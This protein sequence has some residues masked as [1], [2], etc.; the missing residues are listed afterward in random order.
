MK[1]Q[2]QKIKAIG[3]LTIIATA[4]TVLLSPGMIFPDA[5]RNAVR[6]LPHSRRGDQY[7]VWLAVLATMV[8][9]CWGVNLGLIFTS[10]EQEVRFVQWSKRWRK[11]P[12]PFELIKFDTLDPNYHKSAWRYFWDRFKG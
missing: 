3:R 12:I 2:D 4:M 5:T 1:Y 6:W 7:G 11:T 9:I 10:P 8:P